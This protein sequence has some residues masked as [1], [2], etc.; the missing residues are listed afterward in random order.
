MRADTFPLQRKRK[1]VCYNLSPLSLR[2]RFSLLFRDHSFFPPSPPFGS[3]E[4]VARR[5]PPPR[6][7]PT[8]DGGN[9]HP[10]FPFPHKGSIGYSRDRLPTPPPGGG[11]PLLSSLPGDE[12][13]LEDEVSVSPPCCQFK[14]SGADTLLFPPPS[15]TVSS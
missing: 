13:L 9:R 1:R 7:Q 6:I 2:G 5:F 11:G 14:P 4:T 12:A 10:S 15:S 8:P 3:L